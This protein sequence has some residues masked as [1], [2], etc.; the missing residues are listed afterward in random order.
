MTSEAAQAPHGGEYR[1]FVPDLSIPRFTTMA[2]QDAHV[3]AEEFKT[4]GNPPWLHGLY[5]H[6][7]DLLKDPFKGITTDGT[8]Y[9]S[10]H[11]GMYSD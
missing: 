7:L 1:Q 5:M 11:P 6:W 4:G 10:G 3:Y 2:K 8:L 9:P